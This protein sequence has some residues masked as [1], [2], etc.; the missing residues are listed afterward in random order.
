MQY[1][2]SWHILLT[3]TRRSLYL[4]HGF[5][6]NSKA[7]FIRA[8]SKLR[9]QSLCIKQTGISIQGHWDQL[10]FRAPKGCPCTPQLLC[11]TDERGIFNEFCDIPRAPVSTFSMHGGAGGIMSIGLLRAVSFDFMEMCV[12]S[13]YSTGASILP[14]P[15][16]HIIQCF[17][18]I[19]SIQPETSHLYL[20]V[21]WTII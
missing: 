7:C 18:R 15:S 1:A 20:A 5:V 13:L 4:T 3:C 8:K 2:E 14:C 17:V 21:F 9:Q 6:K 11:A 10:F 16:C 19:K 12:K